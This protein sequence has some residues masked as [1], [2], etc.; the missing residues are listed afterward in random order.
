[1]QNYRKINNIISLTSSIIRRSGFYQTLHPVNPQILEILIQ[2]ITSCK[3][4]N[5]GNPDSDKKT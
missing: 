2:T 1:M 4:L 3:S 5:P